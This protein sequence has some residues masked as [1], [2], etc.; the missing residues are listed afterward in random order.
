MLEFNITVKGRSLSDI[1]DG[2]RAALE[3]IEY[4][5]HTG[6]NSNSTGSYSFSSAGQD[7]YERLEEA[8]FEYQGSTWTYLAGDI[9]GL[10]YADALKMA[11]PEEG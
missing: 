4:E 10:S 8:G 3:A 5:N 7:D 11:F 1:Q 2:V 6:F 9:G